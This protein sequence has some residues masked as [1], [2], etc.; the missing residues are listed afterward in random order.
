MEGN[1]NSIYHLSL[2][3]NRLSPKGST[4]P[5][6]LASGGCLIPTCHKTA[7]LKVKIFLWLHTENFYSFPQ[8]PVSARAIKHLSSSS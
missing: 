8:N 5:D 3:K 6:S 2:T 1:Y 7:S 4:S